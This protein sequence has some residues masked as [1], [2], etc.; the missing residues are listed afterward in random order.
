[1]AYR[2]G[3]RQQME[4]LPQSI[5]EYVAKDD[6]VRAYD[7]FIDALD[8]NALGIELNPH[9]VGNAEY[10]P[11]A[12]L[13]LLIYGYSYGIRSSRKLERATY[14]N[15]SFI[16]LVGGLKPDHKTIAE[17]R[18]KNRGALKRVLRECARMCIKL[19]LIVGN[20]LFV[21]GTKI[22]A[23]AGWKKS[24]TKEWYEQHLRKVEQRIEDLLGECEAIDREEEGLESCVR[25]RE[26]L[27]EMET[28]KGKIE[29]IVEECKASG[30]KRVNQTDPDCAV[31]KGSQGSH[32]SYNVQSVVDDRHGLIVHTD[33]VKDATDDNQFAHQIDQANEV[34]ED[35]C[36][37]ACGDAGYADIEE[38]ERIDAQGIKVVVPSRRQASHKP[39]KPLSKRM[40]R[41]DEGRDCY[42]C[43]QGHRLEYVATE[44]SKR[45]K[46][47]RIVERSLC[48]N[49]GH[50]GQCTTDA[51]GRRITRLL[52]EGLREKLEAQ[53]EEATSQMIYKRRKGRVEHPFGHI[54]RNLKA[55]AFMLRGREGVRAETAL[56]ATCYNIVRM[57]T[58]FGGVPGLIQRL[59]MKTAIV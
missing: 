34:L 58:L 2:Y 47:Y 24:Y 1:M 7:A 19:D 25:M 45:R 38:L 9:K 48:F 16:W 41:Y 12:M 28:L 21:D 18:R 44:K 22:R 46:R 14:H 53:Y 5:E 42:Y 49:C 59:M 36:T 15:V 51:A 35:R 27:T 6:P 33:A 43:P 29:E 39:E 17:F 13:K 50:Y 54:K 52:R 3:N 26:E 57:I 20:V 40:F 55:D 4:L 31:M 23:N 30:S 11:K 56:L 10:N 8:F 37:V 32:A